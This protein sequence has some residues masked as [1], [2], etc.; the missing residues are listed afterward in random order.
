MEHGGG[1]LCRLL[2]GARGSAQGGW[3]SF[4][5]VLTGSQDAGSREVSA[6]ASGHFVGWNL[7]KRETAHVIEA[8]SEATVAAEFLGGEPLLVRGSCGCVQE[9]KYSQCPATLVSRVRAFPSSGGSGYTVS[10]S[11]PPSR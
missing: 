10:G 6:S 7:E 11:R 3:G 1:V 2:G 9:Q 5:V 4:W 8:H